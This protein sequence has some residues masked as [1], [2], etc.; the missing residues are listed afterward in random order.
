VV[1][2]SVEP[3]VSVAPDEPVWIEFDQSKIHLFDGETQNALT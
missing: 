3:S 2:V 1:I